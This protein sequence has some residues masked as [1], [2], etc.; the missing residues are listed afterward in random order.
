MGGPSGPTLLDPGIATWHK[1][2]GPEGPPT[3]AAPEP[4]NHFFLSGRSSAR[5]R[6]ASFGSICSARST[7]TRSPSRSTVSTPA[8]TPNTA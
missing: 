7:S 5:R 3:R 8:R 1:S 4:G 6:R 2:L